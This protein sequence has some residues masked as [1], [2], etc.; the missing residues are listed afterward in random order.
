MVIAVARS[1]GRL[2]VTRETLEAGRLD[3][4][5][6]ALALLPKHDSELDRE[7]LDN[8]LC[9]FAAMSPRASSASEKLRSP[10][11]VLIGERS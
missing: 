1:T 11:L 10:K 5:A 4:F 6:A 3:S 9:T 8:R 7:M 2:F